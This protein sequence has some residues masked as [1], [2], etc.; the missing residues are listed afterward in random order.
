MGLADGKCCTFL[1][2]AVCVDSVNK[3]AVPQRIIKSFTSKLQI[4]VFAFSKP[5][6]SEPIPNSTQAGH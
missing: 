4:F 6:S 3:S 5:T 2:E 1:V